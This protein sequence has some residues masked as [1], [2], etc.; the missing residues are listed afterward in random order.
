MSEF[1]CHPHNVVD[2]RRNVI[3]RSGENIAALEVEGVLNA[4]PDVAQVRH[5]EPV[6]GLEEHALAGAR[7][8]FV[9]LSGEAVQLFQ[10]Q[11]VR[12]ALEGARPGPVE[13][14]SVG[15]GTGTRAF[16]WKGGIGTSSRKLP[17]SLGAWAVGVLVQ[18]WADFM[19]EAVAEGTFREDLY[20]RINVVNIS[21]PP[22]RERAGDIELLARHFH[23][24]H[25]Y[26]GTIL[27]RRIFNQIH[28]KGGFTHR[29]SAGDDNQIRALQPGGHFIKIRETGD[30][31]SGLDSS[32]HVLYAVCRSEAGANALAST[33]RPASRNASCQA[34]LRCSAT[35]HEAGP[36]ICAICSYPCPIR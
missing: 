12:A 28:G 19:L 24:E 29:R 11:H 21:I 7:A 4:H 22:L 1:F 20:Y 15:A 34:F 10:R 2:R 9:D 27:D 36:E 35:C 5:Q 3:R 16:G 18:T 31:T 32:H 17:A 14:G 13:E 33:G 26:R 30:Q 25:S 23:A 6:G 8:E